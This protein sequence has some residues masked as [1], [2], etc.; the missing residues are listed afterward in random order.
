[1]EGLFTAPS[2]TR[3][4]REGDEFS[5][6]VVSGVLKDGLTFVEI[7]AYHRPWA[8]QYTLLGTYGS[9]IAGA[10]C[11]RVG[12]AEVNV[13]FLTRNEVFTVRGVQV[14]ARLLDAAEQMA[15]ALQK[16]WLRLESLDD[17]RLLAW[18]QDQGFSPEGEPAF[19]A[20][21]GLLHPMVRPV[22]GP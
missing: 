7:L 5:H 19:D 4:P 22:A 16:G 10:V 2:G 8:N 6:F 21:W 17:H 14:G 1:M 13:D 12:E 9:Q 20:Q 18:Y 11:L 15:R 3:Y